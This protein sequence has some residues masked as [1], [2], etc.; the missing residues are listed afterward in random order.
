MIFLKVPPQINANSFDGQL[1]FHGPEDWH[2]QSFR[3]GMSQYMLPVPGDFY[4][5]PAWQPHS[6]MPFRGEGERWSLAFN[7]M[8][9]PNQ[10]AAANRAVAASPSSAATP[11][12]N[13]HC[14][15]NDRRRK[16]F[17][18]CQPYLVLKSSVAME[19]KPDRLLPGRRFPG[20]T[21][22]PGLRA[23]G[24]KLTSSTVGFAAS[25]AAS[26]AAM[27]LSLIHI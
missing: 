9:I 16:G 1:C 7:A 5:F 20:R 17:E 18:V 11:M 15:V 26:S 25:A 4:V 22:L 2:I 12:G 19:R 3:T 6:V 23:S 14:L 27:A 13:V 10:Q 21:A 24:A 8:A